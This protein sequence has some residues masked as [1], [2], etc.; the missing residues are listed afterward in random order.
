M[1]N[2]ITN[3]NWIYSDFPFFTIIKKDLQISYWHQKMCLNKISYLR[4]INDPNNV[5]YCV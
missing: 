4:E 1:F 5:K 2:I 3:S